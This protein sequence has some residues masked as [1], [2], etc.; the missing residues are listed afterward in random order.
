MPL[1]IFSMPH[2]ETK[3]FLMANKKFTLTYFMLIHFVNIP[4]QLKLY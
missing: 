4:G 2:K 1:E 3:V